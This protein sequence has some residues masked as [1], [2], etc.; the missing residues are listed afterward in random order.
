MNAFISP[1]QPKDTTIQ[2]KSLKW[3]IFR[4]LLAKQKKKKQ[5]QKI[6]LKYNQTK[7]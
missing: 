5:K 7:C 1:A 4:Q 3:Y 6:K 2:T